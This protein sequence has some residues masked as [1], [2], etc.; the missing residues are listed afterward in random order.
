MRILFLLFITCSS[1]AQGLVNTP[2][3]T[4]NSVLGTGYP[5]TTLLSPSAST[6][7]TLDA[8]LAAILTKVGG[9]TLAMTNNLSNFVATIKGTNTWTKLSWL[10]PVCF[11]NAASNQF[12]WIQG[13]P[14]FIYHQTFI[15]NGVGGIQSDGSSGYIDTGWQT[16]SNQNTAS[17]FLWCKSDSS[18]GGVYP[19]A[20]FNDGS[21]NYSVLRHAGDDYWQYGINVNGGASLTKTATTPIFPNGVMVIRTN[22]TTETIFYGASTQNASV[23]SVAAPNLNVYIFNA[24]DNGTADYSFWTG[25]VQG[26]AASNQALTQNDYNALTNAFYNLNVAMG[27]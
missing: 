16:T 25:I 14:N 7:N 9:T 4:S 12:N 3:G 13:G 5:V 1:F 17:I 23:N 8:D 26:F 27:R 19:L 15:T 10:N 21:L 2:L 22:S 18:F 6:N 11:S 20:G 24:N